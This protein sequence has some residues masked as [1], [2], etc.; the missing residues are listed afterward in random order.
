MFY[1]PNR[2]S[3]PDNQQCR[4]GLCRHSLFTSMIL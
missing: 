1:I 3:V 4:V 2:L